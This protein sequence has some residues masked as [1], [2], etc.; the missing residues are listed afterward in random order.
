MVTRM[1]QVYGVRWRA[2]KPCARSCTDFCWRDT[3][4]PEGLGYTGHS[5]AIMQSGPV[6][7]YALQTDDINGIKAIYPGYYPN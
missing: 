6:N 2:V 5:P 3:H 1:P 7:Y 4:L